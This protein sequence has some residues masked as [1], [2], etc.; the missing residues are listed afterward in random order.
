MTWALINADNSWAGGPYDDPPEP[1]EGQRVIEVALGYPDTIVWDAAHNGFV[2]VAPPSLITVGR[3]KL[4]LTK[5]ERVAIRAA[6]A[7]SADVEDFLDLLNGF[8]DG[9]SLSDPIL[10]AAL[11]EMVTA[12]L[13]TADRVPEILAGQAPQ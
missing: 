5:E 4:L 3:F 7:S 13:L 2:D 12:G 10:T 6:A 8:T 11:G 9:I 1:G